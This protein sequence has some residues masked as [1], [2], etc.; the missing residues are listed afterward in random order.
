VIEAHPAVLTVI[1]VSRRGAGLARRLREAIPDARVVV[2]D[3][4]ALPGDQAY[5]RSVRSEIATAFRGSRSLV[6]VMA[7]GIAVRL[8]APLLHD[9][10]TDPGV[11]VV[12]DGGRFAVSLLSG[13]L[14]GANALTERVAQVLGATSVVTTASEAAGLTS[15]DLLGHDYGWRMEPS[16]DFTAVA[17]ALVNG[18]PIGVVQECGQRDAVAGLP[19]H[20]RVYPSIEALLAARPAAALI[21]SDRHTL[22]RTTGVP[23]VIYRPPVLALGAGASRGAPADE[24]L[25][26]ARQALFEGG[27]AEESVGIVATIDKKRDEAA[28]IALAGHFIVPVRFFT[29]EELEAAPGDWQRSAVVSQAVGTGGVCEPAALCAAHACVLAV[30]KRK[31]AHAT[32][33]IARRPEGL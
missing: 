3:R 17:A 31:S 9:K 14:G 32:L 13:H 22:P 6:L 21:V 8:L 26:L 30:P 28:I 27:F 12:D 25:A 23:V 4:F 19:D 11:V 16:S 1:A 15:P 7:T 2:P 5:E 24:L 33:A 29:A 18:D 10:R 20:A